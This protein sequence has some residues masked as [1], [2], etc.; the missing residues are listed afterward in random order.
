[1]MKRS[2]ELGVGD[3]TEVW[4]GLTDGDRIGDDRPKMEDVT[5]DDR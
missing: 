5:T 2:V 3:S 1:M 4:S